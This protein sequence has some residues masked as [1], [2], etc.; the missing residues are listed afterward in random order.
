MNVYFHIDELARDAVVA[1]ALKKELRKIGGKLT[2]GTRITTDRYLAKYNHFDVVILPSLRH[3]EVACQDP[4]VLPENVFILQTEAIGQATGTLRRLN[5]KYFG[6]DLEESR[7]W[8]SAVARYLLWG[9]S[10]L[11]P[12]KEFIPEYLEKCTVVGHPRLADACL[13]PPNKVHKPVSRKVLG[14]VSRF[15]FLSPMD[16][17]IPFESVISSMRFGKRVFPLFENSPDRDV[18]DLAY[19]EIIDFRIMLQIIMTLEKENY[20]LRVRPH[21]RENREGWETIARKLNLKI[22]LS[23]WDEPFGHWLQEL[24]YIVTPPSTSLYDVFF[25]KKKPIVIDHIVSSRAEHTLTESDDRNQILEAVC[26]PKSVE[27][28]VDR[29]EKD[30]IPVK[31]D[32]AIKNLQEQ[33]GF[34]IAHQSIGNIV[35]AMQEFVKNRPGAKTSN[36]DFWKLLN[37]RFRASAFLHLRWIKNRILRRT[38]QGSGFHLSFLRK[39]WID[40]LT[41]ED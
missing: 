21:P 30:D 2:Y 27:E 13:K 40:R 19:T 7:P 6:D 22:T 41:R 28:V 17:R 20:D 14:L 11:N 15:T 34:D 12:F 23:P 24:D 33:V 5:G 26:R 4:E 9:Y 8:H 3:F 32:I 29:L 38:E 37:Y 16:N 18:E 1:S 36:V 31:E 35:E 10:H 39:R 25:Q